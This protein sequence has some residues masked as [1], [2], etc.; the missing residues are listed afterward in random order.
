MIVLASASPRRTELLSSLTSNFIAEAA[1]V[2]EVTCSEHPADIVM[3]LAALKAAAVAAN[4]VGDTV[5]GAD[6]LV[7]HGG[8]ALGKPKDRQDAID[9]LKALR[10]RVHSVF[11]GVCVIKGGRQYRMYD[12]S[13]VAIRDMSDSE[14]EAY[15][16][17]GS[18][19]DK[20]GAYG[21]QDG[22]ASSFTG[23]YDNIVGF[24]TE[25]VSGL[26]ALAEDL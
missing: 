10:G 20:A 17:G 8:R 18:P 24:P 6:T 7:L 1:D 9:T 12:V 21:I 16:D 11:T 25:L 26:P 4:H 2:E 19:M 5:I 15:V 14:I 22:V 23:S 3:D 13:H